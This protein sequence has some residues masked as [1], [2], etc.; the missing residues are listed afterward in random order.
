M[1]GA[2]PAVAEVLSGTPRAGSLEQIA[3]AARYVDGV[4]LGAADFSGSVRAATSNLTDL[5]GAAVAQLSEKLETGLVRGAAAV[6]QCAMAAKA[7]LRAY[8]S[9]VDRVD[10]EAAA[11]TSRVSGWLSN[12]RDSQRSIAA[13]CDAILADHVY[14]WDVPPGATLPEPRLPPAAAGLDAPERA[15]QLHLLRELYGARWQHAAL[16]WRDDLDAIRA[17]EARWESLIDERVRAEGRLVSSLEDTPVGQLA[18]L[19]RGAVGGQ[20]RTI[21]LGLTGEVGGS[22]PRT[23]S[24][25]NSHRLLEPLLGTSDGSGVATSPPAATRV[26]AWWRGLSQ[27]EREDLIELAPVVVGNLP[28]LLPSVRDR[29]NRL[30]ISQFRANPQVLK[31]DQLR[32]IAAIQRSCDAALAQRLARPAVQVLAL[33]LSGRV[34]K[35]AIGYGNLD[36]STHTTWYVPGMDSDA[37]TALPHWDV[38]SRNLL[39]LQSSLLRRSGGGSAG[40][41]SWLGYETPKPLPSDEVLHSDRAA[42][43]AARLA[44]ELDGMYVARLG[45]ESGP[46]ATSVVAHSYGTAVAALAL[47]LTGFPI[48]ALV[49][50]GSAGI[51]PASVPSLGEL[52]VREAAPGQPAIYATNA[53]ADRLAPS[54]AALARRSLP[55]R[56]GKPLLGLPR[57][58]PPYSGVIEFP[59][60]GDPARGLSATDGHSILGDGPRPQALGTTASAGRGYGDPDTQALHTTAR[61]TTQAIDSATAN[62]FQMTP[63]ARHPGPVADPG[64]RTARSRTPHPE[65]DTQ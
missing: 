54:G 45:A 51:D 36:R 3:A 17:A 9:E 37:P 11:L 32:L 10:R 59:S 12:V 47:T 26:A 38:A 49:L 4:W 2:I 8:A 24:P 6:E 61:I 43:G 18:S 35:A 16:S 39:H 28:G 58:P 15:A 27:A 34:P 55:T 21:A 22:V 41:I 5:E 19:G 52:R 53:P 65:E 57:I 1:M 14:K 44:A 30:A 64:D 23:A 62:T 50:L 33:D 29:A 31:P 63:L 46:P 56:Q 25:G 20:H 60:V 48:D 7:A 40:V 42:E 13:I